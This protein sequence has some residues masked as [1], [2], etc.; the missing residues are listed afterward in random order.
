[1]ENELVTR[2]ESH[3]NELAVLHNAI[4]LVVDKGV[5]TDVSNKTRNS[6]KLIRELTAIIFEMEAV[7]RETGDL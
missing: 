1:M 6:I 7:L 3:I 2:I 5:A 4:F